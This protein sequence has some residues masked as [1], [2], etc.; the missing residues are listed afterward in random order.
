MSVKRNI[1][2]LVGIIGVLILLLSASIGY[3]IHKIELPE[4][5]K[6]ISDNSRIIKEIKELKNLY[7]A[8]ISDK[9]TTYMNMQIQKDSIEKLVKT[10]ENSKSNEASLLKYKTEFK[11]LESKMRILVDEIVVLKNKKTIAVVK[12]ESSFNENSI[13]KTTR[14]VAKSEVTPIK[15]VKSNNEAIVNSKSDFVP[16]IQTK[17]T[18]E[19]PVS[20]TKKNSKLS[21]SNVRALGFSSKSGN[22]KTETTEASK[23]DLIKISFNINENNDVEKGER[24]FYF[25]VIN[26]NNNVM[27][28]RITEYFDNES[29]TYSFSKSFDYENKSVQVSQEFFNSNFEKGY[30]F[31]NIFDRNELVGK[32]SILLK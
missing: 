25:Q 20:K 26:S 23:T 2:I 6:A 11:N 1:S 10:L 16:E 7:D 21:L 15:T 3:I 19:I 28:K 18:A 13:V 8:K 24:T 5:G 17:S 9:T 4:S 14:I 32:T 27:G 31:I 30:Y 12:K 29:L 22:K